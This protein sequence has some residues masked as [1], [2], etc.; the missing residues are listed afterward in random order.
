M[1]AL[2][3][4]FCPKLPKKAN[5]CQNGRIRIRPCFHGEI[6]D[7]HGLVKDCS[8]IQKGA[9]QGL[10]FFMSYCLKLLIMLTKKSLHSALGYTLVVPFFKKLLRTKNN[11]GHFFIHIQSC[12]AFGLS[13]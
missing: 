9:K 10:P 4:H 11:S 3:L 12:I 6:F 7:F 2:W 8:D 5:E 1:V 13:C